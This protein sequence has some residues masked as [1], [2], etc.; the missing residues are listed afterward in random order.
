MDSFVVNGGV[1]EN[2]DKP[3]RLRIADRGVRVLRFRDALKPEQADTP[4]KQVYYAI[5]LIITGDLDEETALPALKQEMEALENAFAPLN[6]DLV[7]V[8]R[9]M[10]ERGSYYSA[11][12]HLRQLMP[13]E[14]HLLSNAPKSRVA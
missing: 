1:L 8:L 5:Q 7:P 10:V 14:A 6:A 13:L 11:L 2:S 3:A 4:V 9:R 12:C